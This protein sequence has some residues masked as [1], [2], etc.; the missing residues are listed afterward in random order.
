MNF[1]IRFRKSQPVRDEALKFEHAKVRAR[2]FMEIHEAATVALVVFA[3]GNLWFPG[4]EWGNLS[5]GL[6]VAFLMALVAQLAGFRSRQLAGENRDVA[7]QWRLLREMLVP[8]VQTQDPADVIL[9]RRLTSDLDLIMRQRRSRLVLPVIFALTV[10]AMDPPSPA[11]GFAQMRSGLF[12]WRPRAEITILK[13]DPENPDAS[14]APRVVSIYRY[15]SPDIELL[16][17]NLVEISVREGGNPVIELRDTAQNFV[18]TGNSDGSAFSIT[19]TVSRSTGVYLNSEGRSVRLA[20]IKVLT[21]P[22][23]KVS[24]SSPSYP[25]GSSQANAGAAPFADAWFDDK[26]LP[27]KIG[28]RAEAPVATVKLLIRSGKQESVENVLNVLS[29]DRRDIDTDYSVT[30]EPYIDSDQAEVTL[31]AIA[32]DR[33]V[34]QPL[35]G[36]SEPLRIQVLSS[37][38]R[39]RRTLDTLKELKA[40]LDDAAQSGKISP[41]RDPAQRDGKDEGMDNE[42]KQDLQRLMN[43]A[44]QQSVESPYFDALDR[45]DLASFQ[46]KVNTGTGEGEGAAL[47]DLSA[48]LGEFLFQHE[49]IDQR[50][51]DRDFFVA[52]RT[53]SRVIQVPGQGRESAAARI[54]PRI[55]QFLDERQKFWAARVDRLGKDMTPPQ[56]PGIRDQKPFHR[57]VRDVHELIVDDQ[58]ESTRESRAKDALSRI[59][60][61]VAKYRSWIEELEAREDEVRKRREAER[62]RGLASAEN[63]LRELQRRQGEISGGLDRAQSKSASD[64]EGKWPGLRSTQN[65]NLKGTR[66]LE[67]KIRAFAPGAEGRLKAAVEAMEQTLSNGNSGNFAAAE[68]NSDMAGRL[69]RQAEQAAQRSRDSGQDRGRRRRVNGDN[70]YGQSITGGDVEIKREYEVDRRYREDILDE[71]ARSRADDD[72]KVLLDRYTR[73][74]VR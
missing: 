72:D 13:G 22:V 8:A 55:T 14:A 43:L 56:W 31:V 9:R 63:E 16:E 48:E 54:L 5:R 33:A 18:M 15:R 12:V 62:Q 27:L 42:L 6:V 1:R 35:T 17:G 50:E 25:G 38:G 61:S 69:L 4:Q 7:S 2:L 10:L 49:S 19:L 30:L 73:E 59:A 11:R 51:R 45:S 23:P 65:S 29:D 37:Y 58:K 46:S 41:T 3:L 60:R 34:P 53:L 70:Y 26:P 40:S 71:V 24:L 67:G 74:I 52:M 57:V 20:Q 39:Y 36:A 68:S 64:M 28:V 47:L 21:L 44:M 32:T 66:G